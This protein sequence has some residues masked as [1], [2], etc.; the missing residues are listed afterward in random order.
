MTGS[1]V[2]RARLEAIDVFQEARAADTGLALLFG[3]GNEVID[4]AFSPDGQRVVTAA[5]DRTARIW[6][7]GSGVQLVVFSGHTRSRDGKVLARWTSYRY[8][9]IGQH[10]THLGCI[11]RQTRS[12]S[13]FW[14][15]QSDF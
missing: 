14:S 11:H 6:D 12:R 5:F 2:P 10:R 7:T 8:H 9:I 3:H 1:P 4:A 15:W 13:S